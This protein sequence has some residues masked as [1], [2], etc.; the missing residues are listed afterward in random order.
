VAGSSTVASWHGRPQTFSNGYSNLEK[1]SNAKPEGEK[2]VDF[3]VQIQQQELVVLV[4]TLN[5][6]SVSLK[7]SS[8]T[9]ANHH[10]PPSSLCS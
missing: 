7:L 10:K 3:E 1:N 5:H 4:L 8:T 9:T 6:S 2:T